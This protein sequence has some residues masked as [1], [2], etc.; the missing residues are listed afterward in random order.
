MVVHLGKVP[1]L[2]VRCACPCD[3]HTWSAAFWRHH[4]AM[5]GS[6]GNWTHQTLNNTLR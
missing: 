4:F 1:V 3:C 5:V 6:A 2:I